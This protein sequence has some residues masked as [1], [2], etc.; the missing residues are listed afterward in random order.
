MA[1]G[2]ET[3]PGQLTFEIVFANTSNG[4]DLTQEHLSIRAGVEGE[5]ER[6]DPNRERFKWNAL[7]DLPKPAKNEHVDWADVVDYVSRKLATTGT[8]FDVKA[9]DGIH[10]CYT[11]N[12]RLCY[13]DTDIFIDGK[14]WEAPVSLS[15]GDT[16][17]LAIRAVLVYDGG[18]VWA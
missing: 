10:Y 15:T 18:K 14:R 7:D 9:A 17:N 6:R 16:I 13:Y 1:V 3:V 5:I 8:Q 4:V 12:A 2:N 11:D